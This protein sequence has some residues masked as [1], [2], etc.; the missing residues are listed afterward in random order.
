MLAVFVAWPILRSIWLLNRSETAGSNIHEEIWWEI[1]H[2]LP[3]RRWRRGWSEPISVREH[4]ERKYLNGRRMNLD[5]VLHCYS[6]VEYNQS[7]EGGISESTKKCAISWHS[8]LRQL[9]VSRGTS[10]STESSTSSGDLRWLIRLLSSTYSTRV[11]KAKYFLWWTSRRQMW[12]PNH[13]EDSKIVWNIDCIHR[14]LAVAR[15]YWHLNVVV[16]RQRDRQL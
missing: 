14:L 7:T 16:K 13:Q 6:C 11:R 3:T 10:T 15:M 2:H 8:I 9:C 5:E 1:E 12:R 4:W